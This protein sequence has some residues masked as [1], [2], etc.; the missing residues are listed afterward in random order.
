MDMPATVKVGPHVYTILRKSKTQM[1]KDWGSCDNG[2]L[3]IW[4]RQRLR[5]SKAREILVHELMHAGLHSVTN[6]PSRNEEE[7][8]VEALSPVLL[9]VLQDNPELV[10]YLTK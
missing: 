9:Q 7:D 3:Q 10:E 6:G 8:F 1:P 5:K 2:R 4:V